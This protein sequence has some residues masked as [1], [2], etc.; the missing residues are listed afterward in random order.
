MD[1]VIEEIMRNIFIFAIVVLGV[2]PQGARAQERPT[3]E[4]SYKE[5]CRNCAWGGPGRQEFICE[6]RTR[7]GK[8]VKAIT[9]YGACRSI[10]NDNG[11]LVCEP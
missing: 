2:I 7:E 3:P 9:M 8:Y 5:T 4:G 1:G 6:C 10:G 11:R